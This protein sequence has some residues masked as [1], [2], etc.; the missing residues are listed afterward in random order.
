MAGWGH[1]AAGKGAS[2]MAKAEKRRQAVKAGFF[3]KVLLCV[4]L[5]ALGFQLYR[6]QG[7]KAKTGATGGDSGKQEYL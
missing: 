6:L 7:Q 3:T 1:L 2:A 5:V 4:L